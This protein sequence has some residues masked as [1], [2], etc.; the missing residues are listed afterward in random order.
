VVKN[1]V[2][3]G[4]FNICLPFKIMK[5]KIL[6]RHTLMTWA[7]HIY[8]WLPTKHAVTTTH[9][10]YVRCPSL[11]VLCQAFHL[12]VWG[13]TYSGGGMP[14]V[15]LEPVVTI[16]LV[17]WHVMSETCWCPFWHSEDRALWCILIM[18]ANEMQYFSDYLI[19]YSTC[20]RQIYC[21]S[22]GV[23][24]H[25]IRAIGICHASYVGVC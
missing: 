8:D 13:S 25:C 15:A 17:W 7:M 4:L 6:W 11:H 5:S 3:N 10:E 19:K 18:K 9:V 12:W 1:S 2:P 23:S 14:W 16:F 24:Q 22:S 20:F 21:P